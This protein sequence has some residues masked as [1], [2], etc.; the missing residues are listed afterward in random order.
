MTSG[1]AALSLAGRRKTADALAM[2]TAATDS[3]M[4]DVRA[5][6]QWWDAMGIWAAV[7]I[8]LR[9]T[10]A[11]TESLAGPAGVIEGLLLPFRGWFPT[12]Q[13]DLLVPIDVDLGFCA[14]SA[15]RV[16]DAIAYFDSGVALCARTGVSHH[17]ALAKVMLAWA[18]AE[19]YGRS[20]R[21]R[22]LELVDAAEAWAA[23]HG[24]NHFMGRNFV[25]RK[26]VSE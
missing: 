20:A 26:L 23:A 17:G 16:D 15:G 5:D 7:P 9:L 4:S 21:G 2:L 12:A 19:A 1:I 10:G 3:R 24:T 25:A 22:V 18:L 8:V 13:I 14:L 11:T 6:Y